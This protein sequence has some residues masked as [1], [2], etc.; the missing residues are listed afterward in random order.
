MTDSRP[1]AT[2]TDAAPVPQTA[3]ALSVLAMIAAI[4][5]PILGIVLA[6]IAL[7]QIAKSARAGKD[8]ATAA[9]VTAIVL[10]LIGGGLFLLLSH[11][12]C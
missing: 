6:I 2:P 11:C 1:A 10:T 12:Q 3:S 7:A 8:L 5:F 4:V 9:L